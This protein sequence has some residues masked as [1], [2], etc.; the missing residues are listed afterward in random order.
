VLEYKQQ[1]RMRIASNSLPE[2]VMDLTWWS[3]FLFR[4]IFM[5]SAYEFCNFYR[6]SIKKQIKVPSLVFLQFKRFFIAKVNDGI[7]RFILL[8]MSSDYFSRMFRN[9]VLFWHSYTRMYFVWKNLH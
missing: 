9:W 3:L 1:L 7:L 8:L 2:L 4:R 5:W 6:W